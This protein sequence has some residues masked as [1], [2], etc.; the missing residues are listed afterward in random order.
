MFKESYLML[1]GDKPDLDDCSDLL[2]NDEDLAEELKK[3]TTL[4]ERNLMTILK[5]IRLTIT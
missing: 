5:L 4:V 2:E 1:D 3:I